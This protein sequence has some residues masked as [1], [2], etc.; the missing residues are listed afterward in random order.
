MKRSYDPVPKAGPR[1]PAKRRPLPRASHKRLSER[2]QRA[3]VRRLTIERAG[4]RCQGPA[5]GLPGECASP[6]LLRPELEV[7]ETTARGTHP[8]SHLDPSC[9]VALCQSHH[10]MVTSPVGE[11]RKLCES[12]GLIKRATR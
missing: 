2:E 6:D 4:H 3:E 10:S 1:P 5:Y 11:M 8:G 9:T 12:V 7:H